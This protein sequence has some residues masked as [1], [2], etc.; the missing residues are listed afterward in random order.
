MIY[1]LMGEGLLN[2]GNRLIAQPGLS[3]KDLIL[4]FTQTV[5][6]RLYSMIAICMFIRQQVNFL[7]F[8]FFINILL[9]KSY[10]LVPIAALILLIIWFLL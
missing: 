5:D 4:K 2:P 6:Y 3:K 8:F 10:T 9:A 1:S 7:S